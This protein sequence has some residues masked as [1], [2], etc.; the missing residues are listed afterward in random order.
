MQQK[1]KRIITSVLAILLALLLAVPAFAEESV[2]DG[3]GQTQAGAETE[4]GLFSEDP[5]TEPEAE[6][7]DGET[8][9]N[10]PCWHEFRDSVFPRGGQDGS[11][12]FSRISARSCR[13]CSGSIGVRGMRR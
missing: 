10:V 2:W 12:P 5:E 3:F 13:S 1:Q 8:R 9:M 11:S 6:T 4:E 7:E